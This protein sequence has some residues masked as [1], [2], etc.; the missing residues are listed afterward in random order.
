MNNPPKSPFKKG[1][2]KTP[3]IQDMALFVLD[4]L[5]I[6]ALSRQEKSG[7]KIPGRNQIPEAV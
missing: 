5:C 7:W 3:D 2:L 4:N 1:G 6:A